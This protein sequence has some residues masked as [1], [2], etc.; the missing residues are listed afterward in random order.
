M[1][2]KDIF[3]GTTVILLI[4]LASVLGIYTATIS[5]GQPAPSYGEDSITED[6]NLLTVSGTGVASVYPDRVKIQMAI[7]TE[8]DTA[9][10]A[11]TRN[12]E[13][14]NALLSALLDKNIPRDQIETVQYTIYP[15]YDYEE[16]TQRLIGYRMT[17]SVL[18]T[19][20]SSDNN[21]L[22]SVAGQLIDAVVAAGVNQIN[23]IQFTISEETIKN[24]RSDALR[25][26]V[27]DARA[28]ADAITE[29]LEV[30]ILGVDQV[31]ESSYLP[32]PRVFSDV[33]FEGGDA[34]TELVPGELKVTASVQIIYEISQ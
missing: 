20:I 19:V 24:L 9:D 3:L 10:L 1:E 22:G 27:S 15:V 14:F 5:V 29:A 12:A 18:V 7:V 32:T 30:T 6:K 17:H 31:S 13:K 34:S 23:N 33:A 2:K 26:A 8:G 11:S 4:S 21:G 16:R 25:D 28:K